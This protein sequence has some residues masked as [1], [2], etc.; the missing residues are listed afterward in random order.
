MGYVMNLLAICMFRDPVIPNT[1]LT[2]TQLVN[3]VVIWDRIV[4]RRQDARVRIENGQN[5][6][7]FKEHSG[8]FRYVGQS[9]LIGAKSESQGTSDAV[10]FSLF[11]QKH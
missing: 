2:I 5:K 8:N 11:L 9:A 4:R 1:D 3:E 7:V 6:Y 10:S